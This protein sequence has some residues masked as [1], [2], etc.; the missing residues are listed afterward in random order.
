MDTFASRGV[1]ER[2]GKVS[3]NMENICKAIYRPLYT[4]EAFS[5]ILHSPSTSKGLES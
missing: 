4:T 2:T 1:D 3:N 5:V